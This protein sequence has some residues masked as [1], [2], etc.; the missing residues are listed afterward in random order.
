MGRGQKIL[1]IALWALAALCMI[2]LVT[3]GVLAK[4]YRDQRKQDVALANQPDERLPVL[5]RV[6][7]FTLTDQNNATF[8]RDDLKGRVWVADFIFTTCPGIC[9]TMTEKMSGLSKS[10]PGGKVNFVSFSLDPERDK[11][12]VLMQYAKNWK[13]DQTR[14]HFLTGDASKIFD[15]ARGTKVAAQPATETSPIVHSEKFVLVDAA[16]NI[17]GYYNSTDDTEMKALVTDAT[18]LASGKVPTGGA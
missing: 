17:R 7:A 2:G 9:P 3:T 5:F 13:A 11:P 12:P 14:W 15:I 18:D 16:G 1:T 6:P 8:N 10:L 4:R